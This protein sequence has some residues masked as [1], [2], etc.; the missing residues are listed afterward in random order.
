[1]AFELHHRVAGEGPPILLIH[2]GGPDGDMWGAE[3]EDLAQDHRVIAY[4]RRG[5]PG[6]GEP[7]RDWERHSEDAAGLLRDLAATPATVVGHS[8]GAIVALDLALRHPELVSSLVLMDP[9]VYG[10]RHTTP[11]LARAFVAAQ[12][13]RRFRGEQRGAEIFIRWAVS[14]STGGSAWD[15]DDYLE[16][17][18]RG[19]RS[20]AAALF[21]D[22]AAGDGSHIPRDQLQTIRC[23]VTLVVGELSPSWFHRTARALRRDLP[24]HRFEVIQGAG[25]ALTFDKPS[26]FVRVARD[27]SLGT[28]VAR[29][30]A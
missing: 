14:Y 23:P 28:G 15:R 11:G 18:R 10:R 3:F 22:L 6:S 29:A 20:N 1:M 5:Y 7:I 30:S 4:S 19:M 25:H 27:A 13:A 24:E 12:L 16:E 17:W 8:A 21:A 2:G 9:A 26:E